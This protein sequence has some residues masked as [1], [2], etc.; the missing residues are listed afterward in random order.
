M[1]SPLHH[2]RWIIGSERFK[3]KYPQKLWMYLGSKDTFLTKCD[4]NRINI[5]CCGLH[6]FLCDEHILSNV[7]S[8]YPSRTASVVW[9]SEFLPTVPEV[10]GSIPGATRFSEEQWVSNGVH[11]AS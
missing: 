3:S 1:A 9:W 10:L 6:N 11:S 2:F 7:A 4:L 5:V 8:L